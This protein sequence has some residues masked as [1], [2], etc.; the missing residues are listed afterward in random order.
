MI[1][2][3]ALSKGITLNHKQITLYLLL[4]KLYEQEGNYEKAYQFQRKYYDR[5]THFHSYH[6]VITT[7]KN[8]IFSENISHQKLMMQIAKESELRATFTDKLAK[9]SEAI[10][11][12]SSLLFLAVALLMYFIFKYQRMGSVKAY[13]LLEKANDYLEP[14]E[15]T[16]ELYQYHYKKARK[17]DYSIAIGYL[18]IDNWKELCFHFNK[19]TVAEVLQNIALLINE[20][21]GEFD[22]AGIINE[23]EYLLLCPHQTRDELTEKLTNLT[24]ALKVRFFANLGDFSV[25]INFSCDE[26]GV[27]DIDPY[28]F[29]SRL[30][31]ST[32]SDL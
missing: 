7:R 26:P 2:A 20:N 32:S 6:K 29:L 21:K 31:E 12:L 13:D 24:E 30:S 8:P 22:Q 4:A 23:G 25:K 11:W 9:K 18:S 16:K 5:F 15:K 19:Q 17:Y 28:I 1:K 27:Q 14:P 10:S 3:L